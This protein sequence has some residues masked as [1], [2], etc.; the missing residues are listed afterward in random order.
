M[1][2]ELAFGR[3]GRVLEDGIEP[4]AQLRHA[5]LAKLMTQDRH[6]ALAIWHLK[7]SRRCEKMPEHTLVEEITT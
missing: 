4:N 6:A 7:A 1:G 3:Y 5:E 2:R